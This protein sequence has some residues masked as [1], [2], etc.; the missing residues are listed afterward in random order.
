MKTKTRAPAQAELIARA[1][2]ME[3]GN[4]KEHRNYLTDEEEKRKK[5]R[6][7]RATVEGP[8]LRWVTKAEHIKV[9]TEPPPAP[10]PP[11]AP[12]PPP[13]LPIVP[14]SQYAY[15]FPPYSAPSTAPAIYST[16]FPNAPR[17][18]T[19]FYHSPQT[20]G[21]PPSYSSQ[22][23]YGY[24]YYTPPPP[25][26]SSSACPS[27]PPAFVAAAPPLP[28]PEPI[29]VTQTVSKCY[30]VHENSQE[31]DATKPLWKDTMAAM[32]GDHVKWE[33]LKVYTGKGR[34]ICALHPCQMIY[35][36]YSK[37]I[38]ARPD[39]KCP[40]TGQIAR[41]RDPRTGVPFANARAFDVLT[42][43]LAHEYVWSDALGCYT[44]H[45]DQISQT[46]TV[47]SPLKRTRQQGRAASISEGLQ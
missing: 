21:F 24:N 5:A 11:P 4:I 2:D 26:Q 13:T 10:V 25:L 33:D 36:Y 18:V 39:Q 9:K 43:V 16:P 12:I 42:K 31:E 23:P 20:S 6:L 37:F 30:V 1:L 28:P 17:P 45:Q 41:Y 15:H 34:P 46:E 35:I 40:I 3:E 44:A 19:S 47:E 7:V 8:L 22:N 38:V 27:Q 32:F 14:V 29:E